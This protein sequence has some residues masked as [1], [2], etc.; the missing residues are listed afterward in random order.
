MASPVRA[1][2]LHMAEGWACPDVLLGVLCSPGSQE[3]LWPIRGVL[4]TV[5]VSP[6]ELR[7]PGAPLVVVSPM[8]DLLGQD[9][10]PATT[11]QTRSSTACM[12]PDP[13]D[14]Y[15]QYTGPA[16]PCL[17]CP[18]VFSGGTASMEPRAAIVSVLSPRL[19]HQQPCQWR[20]SQPPL[21]NMSCKRQTPLPV[22]CAMRSWGQVEPTQQFP[23]QR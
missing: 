16:S 11:S 21:P 17:R 5:S 7:Q 13:S 18:S 15:Y 19:V 4:D 2:L 8:L 14:T 6:L 1:R 9:C 23:G 20:R 10:P 3:G 22:P 12:P